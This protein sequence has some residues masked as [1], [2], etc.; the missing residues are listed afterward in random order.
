MKGIKLW[1][2]LLLWCIAVC[3]CDHKEKP[4]NDR[5][6]G[7]KRVIIIST[8]DIHAQITRFPQFATYVK[9]KKEEG[10]VILVD[11]G[12][13][14]SGNPYVDNA[15][16]K[17]KPMIDLMN[18]LGYDVA[19]LG[20]HDFDY[21]QKV[22]KK[23]MGEAQFPILCANLVSENSEL[24]VLPPWQI[25]ERAGIKFCFFSLI[26]TGS[27]HIPATN[28]ANLKEISFKYYK[29]V[30][31]EYKTLKE[32]CD[33]LIGLTHLGFYNDSLLALVMPE[34]DVIV[35]GHSHTLIREARVVNGVYINQAGSD[36]QYAGV[37]TLTFD[38]KKLKDKAYAVV[39]LDEIGKGD[40]EVALLVKEI[41]DQPEF[42]QVVGK[43]LADMKYKENVA[44]LMTDAMCDAAACDFAFCNKGGVRLNSIPA[45]EITRETVYK[46][47]PFSNYIVKQEWTLQELEQWLLKNFNKPKDK[48]KRFI[49]FFISAGSYEIVRNAA[50]EGIKVNFY[51]ASHRQLKDS[52]R[53]YKV[54]FSNY[55]YSS[56]EDV[57]DKGGEETGIF[58]AEAMI[59]YLGKMQ[60][61]SYTERRTFIQ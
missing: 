56:N 31:R 48:E 39:R 58:I 17:G 32:N 61:V 14:F 12:D 33:V 7:E 41:N 47:E 55:V 59:G 45:G 40:P 44:S 11:A 27:Q 50:G 35:G 5:T 20:N 57:K 3:A 10:E 18:K 51:D 24:G 34:L 15:S 22:L 1:S 53:V 52:Q 36:L 30:A 29:D 2:I 46:I 60:G 6:E 37:T 16:E 54:A 21:G 23:R 13:R 8:N 9:Q 28:P 38:G 25:V 49:S 42:K 26:E 43:A 19:A 4:E